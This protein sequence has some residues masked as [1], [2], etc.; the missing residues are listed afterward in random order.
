MSNTGAIVSIPTTSP[1]HHVNQVS[2][3]L[4]QVMALL[5]AKL[6]TPTVG[7]TK[8][9]IVARV[10][11]LKTPLSS[12]GMRGP[13]MRRYRN[14]ASNACSVDPTAMLLAA[15]TAVGTNVS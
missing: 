9:L 10:M 6:L 12:C 14:A 7:A 13:I 2:G 3:Y 4:L 15:V 1:N 5:N 11:K 8:Q